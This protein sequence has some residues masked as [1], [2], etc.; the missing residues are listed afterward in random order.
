MDTNIEPP[1]L[2]A[3]RRAIK[4]VGNQTAFGELIGKAQQTVS[5]LFSSG[6]GLDAED[7]LLVEE[8]TG[9]PRWEL[10]PDIYPPHLG[11]GPEALITAQA[12]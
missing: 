6:K 1:H 4:I 10:R 5:Y 12:A 8:K 3:L 11:P 7:V 9:V 2:A